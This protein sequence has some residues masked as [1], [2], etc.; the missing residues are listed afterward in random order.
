MAITT[1]RTANTSI[2]LYPNEISEVIS[3]TVKRP[4]KPV[5]NKN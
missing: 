5:H 4:P 3:I 1:Q 2:I